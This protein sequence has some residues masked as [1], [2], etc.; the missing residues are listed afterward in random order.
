MKPL[1]SK[2]MSALSLA[3][4]MAGAFFTPVP[5]YAEP[6]CPDSFDGKT[7]KDLTDCI[8]SLQSQLDQLKSSTSA[9]GNM[10]VSAGIVS[11]NSSIVEYWVDKIRVISRRSERR[12]EYILEFPNILDKVPVVISGPAARSGFVPT[13]PT[14][15]LVTQVSRTEFTVQVLDRDGTEWGSFWFIVFA[16]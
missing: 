16:P 3:S 14:S 11:D 4:V 2:G 5:L 9:T 15:T 13:S 8:K 12:G 7:A 6:G 10:I 1:H